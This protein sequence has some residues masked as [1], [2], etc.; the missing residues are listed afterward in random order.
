MCDFRM[1]GT[2][3]QGLLYSMELTQ[4]HFYWL[5]SKGD[6]N[7]IDC[8]GNEPMSEATDVYEYRDIFK[9]ASTDFYGPVIKTEIS[10]SIYLYNAVDADE[11]NDPC[12]NATFEN[13]SLVGFALMDRR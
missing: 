5:D 9:L 13:G 1:F 6:L 4:N 8:D 11:L 2:P 3:F 12:V 7:T 10:G